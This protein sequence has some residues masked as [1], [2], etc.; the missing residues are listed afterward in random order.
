ML[1]D[2]STAFTSNVENEIPIKGHLGEN[3]SGKITDAFS[4]FR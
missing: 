2:T 3:H 1:K 4:V